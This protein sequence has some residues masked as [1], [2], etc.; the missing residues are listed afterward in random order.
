MD[1]FS[2]GQELGPNS[3]CDLVRHEDTSDVSGKGLVAL[4]DIPKDTF[5]VAFGGTVMWYSEYKNLAIWKEDLAIQVDN[6]LF[7]GPRNKK[8]IT[9]G[10]HV[11]HSCDPNCGIFGPN[12][13]VSL[14]KIRAG[15]ELYFD[16]AMSESLVG[17]PDCQCKTNLCREDVK[18]DDWK[19]PDLQV[20]YGLFFS[21]YLLR[22]IRKDPGL[23]FNDQLFR[24]EVPLGG[25][26]KDLERYYKK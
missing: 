16:Y 23:M 25:Q 12:Y 3:V 24:N 14:K 26:I 6:H 19:R 15:E 5:L 13:L 2:H 20:K 10:D 22:K 8:E 9:Y 17:L 21:T 1:I 7:L 4:V 18:T 11:N